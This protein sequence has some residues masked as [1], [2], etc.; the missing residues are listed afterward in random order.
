LAAQQVT[1]RG[2]AAAAPA[3]V[4]S[5]LRDYEYERRSD[6]DGNAR[7]IGSYENEYPM[8]GTE[9]VKLFIDALMPLVVLVL[10]QKFIRAQNKS[11]RARQDAVQLAAFLEHLSSESKERRKL[12]LLALTHMGDA[13]L[14]PRVLLRSVQSIAVRDDPEVAAFAQLALGATRA[15]EDLTEQQRAL[16]FE[17]LLP[18]KVHLERSDHVFKRWLRNK[19]KKPNVETEDAIKASNTAISALLR[20]KWHLLPE[21]LEDDAAE[22]LDHYDKWLAEYHRVRP[23]GVRNDELYVFA[24]GFPHTA[25]ANFTKHYASLVDQHPCKQKSR[26]G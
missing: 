6:T 18:V 2:A 21:E 3:S 5:A 4:G 25:E 13:N 9:K 15:R 22:L 19:L 24:Y 7:E 23:G 10:G 1:A 16:L 12:A 20:A 8:T 17:L 14:F 11:E 26:A